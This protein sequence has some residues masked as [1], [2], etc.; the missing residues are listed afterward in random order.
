MSEI[1]SILQDKHS[2]VLT[3]SEVGAEGERLAK[4][5]IEI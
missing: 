4:E 5:F 3:T 1:I 2:E